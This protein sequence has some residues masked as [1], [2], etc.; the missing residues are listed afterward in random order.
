MLAAIGCVDVFE[1][2]G[3]VAEEGGVVG[4]GFEG[5]LKVVLGLV[6]VGA[7]VGEEEGVDA[8]EGGVV[9][10]SCERL[11]QELLNEIRS[12]SAIVTIELSGKNNGLLRGV[13][14]APTVPKRI[15][16]PSSPPHPQ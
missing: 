5:A 1:E 8:E 14:I 3:V 2:D 9:A 6:V 7:D 4:V 15:W 16:S 13:R 12:F 10:V 11:G